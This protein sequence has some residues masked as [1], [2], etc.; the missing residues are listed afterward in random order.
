MKTIGIIG[1]SLDSSAIEY[2]K[3]IQSLSSEIIGLY[4]PVDMMV[5][6]ILQ[7]DDDDENMSSLIDAYF[8]VANTQVLIL[9]SC[10]LEFLFRHI[11]FPG[12]RILSPAEQLRKILRLRGIAKIVVLFSFFTKEVR[13]LLDSMKNYEIQFYL[14][15]NKDRLFIK[16]MLFKYTFHKVHTCLDIRRLTYQFRRYKNYGME[17]IVTD[18]ELILKLVSDLDQA[19]PLFYLKDLQIDA[20]VEFLIE[21]NLKGNS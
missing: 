12:P 6:S 18:S 21:C 11:Q 17:A 7:T 9:S 19:L 10:Y 20:V 3:K 16:K 4:E 8:Y 13:H 2:C 14:P 5:Y 15:P 1:N